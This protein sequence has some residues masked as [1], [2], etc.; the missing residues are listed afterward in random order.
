MTGFSNTMIS[1]PTISELDNLYEVIKKLIWRIED[2][3]SKLN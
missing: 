1:N 3:E 2:L